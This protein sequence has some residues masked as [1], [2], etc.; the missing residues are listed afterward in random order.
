M[1]S[2]TDVL[3]FFFSPSARL[4]V[5]SGCTTELNPLGHQFLQRLFDKYDEVSQ[6]LASFSPFFPKSRLFVD[7]KHRVST[8]KWRWCLFWRSDLLCH[9]TKT[10]PCRPPSWR[11]SSA[12]VP[13]CRG[14]PRSTWPSPPRSRATS[15]TWVSAVSGRTCLTP[16]RACCTGSGAAPVLAARATAAVHVGTTALN[17]CCHWCLTQAV[18]IPWHPPLPGAPGIP[19][20]PH[21]H[22]A[23]VTDVRHH[24]CVCTAGSS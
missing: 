6:A 13:T 3:Q 14:A 20:L 1:F 12:C 15:P 8:P 18:C 22:W 16:L 21:P 10:R 9:R 2:F 17:T 19:G 24:R 4:R 5:P 23:G 7:K 11:I